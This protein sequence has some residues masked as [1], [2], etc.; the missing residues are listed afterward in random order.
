M[1]VVTGYCQVTGSSHVVAAGRESV[2]G[3]MIGGV[4]EPHPD[5]LKQ[6]ETGLARSLYRFRQDGGGYHRDCRSDN[7]AL[8]QVR[9]IHDNPVRRG[10]VADPEQWYWS[11]ARCWISGETGPVAVD[12]GFLALA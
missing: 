8:K 6:F 4:R 11:S 3:K 10:L 2:S 5:A 1:R 7:E 9:Y 12:K